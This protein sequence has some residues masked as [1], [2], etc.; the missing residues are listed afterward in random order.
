LQNEVDVE[1]WGFLSFQGEL[2]FPPGI[3]DVAELPM[4]T[5]ECKRRDLNPV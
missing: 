2:K 3:F 4:G 1:F 5:G